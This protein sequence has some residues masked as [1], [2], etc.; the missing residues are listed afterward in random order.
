MISSTPSRGQRPSEG[1]QYHHGDLRRALVCAALEVLNTQGVEAIS[2]RDVA[3][4]A[5]VSHAAPYRHFADKQALLHAMALAG[6]EDLR[7]RLLAAR[8]ASNA[9]PVERLRALLKAYQAFGSAQAHQLN[10][11]FGAAVVDKPPELEALALETFAVLVQAV[12]DAFATGASPAQAQNQ[13]PARAIALSLWAHVH[14]LFV[15]GRQ[16]DFTA[17]NPASKPSTVL[18]ASIDLI[19]DALSKAWLGQR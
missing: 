19:V 2:L 18:E 3:R 16:V 6:F 4:R 5:G 11:M 17:L 13:D 15:L 9:D 8:D 1:D 10:L 14:G 12:S 7:L